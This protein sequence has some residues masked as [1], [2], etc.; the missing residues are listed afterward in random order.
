MEGLGLRTGQDN[1]PSLKTGG[2]GRRVSGEEGGEWEEGRK[3]KFLNG[4]IKK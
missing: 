4:K 2:G 3:Q 1:L